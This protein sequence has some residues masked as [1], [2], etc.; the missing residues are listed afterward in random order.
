MNSPW[1]PAVFWFLAA[2]VVRFCVAVLVHVYSIGAGFEGFYPLESGHDDRFY[3]ET[4]T[5]IAEG[6]EPGALPSVYPLILGYMFR[7]FGADLLLGKLINSVL[8]AFSVMLGVLLAERLRPWRGH[9][10]ALKR[11]GHLAGFLLTLYPSSLFYSTQLLKDPSILVLGMW[12]LYIFVVL[13]NKARFSYTLVAALV[14]GLLLLFRP[15]AA[16]ALWLAFGVFVLLKR[17]SI[18]TLVLV[19]GLAAV[20]PWVLGLGPFALSYLSPLLNPEQ[21]SEFRTEV[22]G[23]GGSS[24][25]VSLEPSNPL[26]F[27]LGWLYS[28]VTVL[29]GPFPWQVKSP[30]TA[31]ALGEASLM[32]ILLLRAKPSLRSLLR[33]SLE[34]LPLVS[35]LV[36]AGVIGLFSDNVGANTRL[37]LLAWSLMFVYI[38]ARV[39]GG[40]ASSLRHNPR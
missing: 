21:I 1:M 4:A 7:W 30:V 16:V 5:Q 29:L 2:L 22:Y 13:Y 36:L 20:V 15:Y 23:I 3:F 18:R 31:L 38:A 40:G 8:G 17:R 34:E 39:G 19:A 6:Y 12:L 28:V 37:R 24:L 14:S 10:W 27:I 33:P 26:A 11:S 25:G 9:P 32:W 35:A